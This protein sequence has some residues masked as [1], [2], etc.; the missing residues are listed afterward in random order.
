MLTQLIPC[1]AGNRSQGFQ[2]TWLLP[3]ACLQMT[4]YHLSQEQHLR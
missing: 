2:K 4:H 1:Q 3:P